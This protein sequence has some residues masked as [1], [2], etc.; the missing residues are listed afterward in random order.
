MH[1]MQQAT[2]SGPKSGMLGYVHPDTPT[3]CIL[4]F[5]GLSGEVEA[6]NNVYNDRK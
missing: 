4:Y 5:L 3:L 2:K 1:D 6:C